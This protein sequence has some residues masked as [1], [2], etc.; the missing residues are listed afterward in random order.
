MCSCTP[1]Y[2]I[3]NTITTF[4]SEMTTNAVTFDPYLSKTV[5]IQVNT[6]LMLLQKGYST[7]R[8]REIWLLY[9]RYVNGTNWEIPSDMRICM[10][11]Y[12]NLRLNP[13][14]WSDSYTRSFF[15]YLVR[16]VPLDFSEDHPDITQSDV[17]NTVR[18][19]EMLLMLSA[20]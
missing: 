5:N 10:S 14:L 7:R 16:R 8:L 13:F 11:W 20:E 15:L 3:P 19:A 18:T 2:F 1:F 6:S 17:F 4:S 9:V 12:T